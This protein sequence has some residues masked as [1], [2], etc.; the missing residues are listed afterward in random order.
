MTPY[1]IEVDLHLHTTHSD[2]TLTPKELV[3]LCSARGLK[4]IAITDHDSTEGLPEAM[5]AAARVQNLEIIPGIELS[6]DLNGQEVHILGYF[7]NHCDPELQRILNELR[8][9]R[10][11]RARI[12]VD[13]LSEIGVHISWDRVQELSG[14]GAIGRPH[15]AQAIVEAKYVEYPKDA[16]NQYLGRGQPA[17]IGRSKLTPQSAIRLL[18]ERGAF[19]VMAHP[20]FTLSETDRPNLSK[21]QPVVNELCRVGLVGMEVHYK[22]YTSKQIQA[23]AD[24]SYEAGLIPFGGTDYHAS[25]NPGEPEPGYIGPPMKTVHR[26]KALRDH[27]K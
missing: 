19:P 14:G 23:L 17:Y 6:T 25:G 13:K 8:D 7:I 21:I 5:Q 22:D 9:G 15:I 3:N 11:N 26:L 27:A 18:I 12:I 2:G 10:I 24:I 1:P 4:V 16:F 20:T